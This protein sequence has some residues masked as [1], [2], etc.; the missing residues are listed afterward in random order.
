MNLAAIRDGVRARLEMVPG[1]RAHDTIPD[2]ISIATQGKAKAVAVVLPIEG[3]FIIYHSTMGPGLCEIRVKVTL[4]ASRASSGHGQEAL[5]ALL[6]SG[7][8]Q[9]VSVLDAVEGER[10]L[11]GTVDDCIVETAGDYGMTEVGGQPCWKADLTLFM[12]ARRA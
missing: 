6:S 12:L 5:D 3:E 10:T 1:L 8:G 11:G 4:L 2:S 7:T 9:A